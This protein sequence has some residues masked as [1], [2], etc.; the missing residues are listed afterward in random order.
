M[1]ADMRWIGCLGS[2]S[3]KQYRH[4]RHAAPRS[5][6]RPRG[7]LP[8]FRRQTV[9]TGTLRGWADTKPLGLE[10]S[11]LL[12]PRFTPSAAGWGSPR[13]WGVAGIWFGLWFALLLTG[14]GL[15][16]HLNNLTKKQNIT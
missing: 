10:F 2:E 13:H 7:Q 3:L 9:A 14:I 5:F 11:R 4:P 6:A 15:T 1:K 16:T 8:D 12:G